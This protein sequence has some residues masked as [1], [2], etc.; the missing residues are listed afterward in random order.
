MNAVATMF[1]KDR[2]RQQLNTMIHEI[3]YQMRPFR[4][5]GVSI[6]IVETMLRPDEV[7]VTMK[8]IPRAK[9]RVS[10]H[11]LMDHSIYPEDWPL[12]IGSIAGQFFS[13]IKKERDGHLVLGEN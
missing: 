2:E 6:T 4:P 3:S 11:E 12:L 10:M 7:V 8:N 13:N 5:V 9:Y 1:A